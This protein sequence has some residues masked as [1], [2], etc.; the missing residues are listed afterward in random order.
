MDFFLQTY[1]KLDGAS[2]GSDSSTAA[3]PG[4]TSPLEMLRGGHRTST[5]GLTSSSLPFQYCP[6]VLTHL[7]VVLRYCLSEI[8]SAAALVLSLVLP[9]KEVLKMKCDETGLGIQMSSI[10]ALGEHLPSCAY[11]HVVY[12]RLT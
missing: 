8:D 11:T 6:T 10:V 5:A 9:C 2:S 3:H 7:C 1:T 12:S 4:T